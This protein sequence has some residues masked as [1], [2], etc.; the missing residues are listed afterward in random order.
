MNR[1]FYFGMAGMR[2]NDVGG[3]CYDDVLLLSRVK[4]M[5]G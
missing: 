4:N 5:A 3:S 1:R 2:A